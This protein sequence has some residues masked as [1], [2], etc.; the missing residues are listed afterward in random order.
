MT[1]GDNVEKRK[2]YPIELSYRYHDYDIYDKDTNPVRFNM[3]SGGIF[4]ADSGVVLGDTDVDGN[5]EIRDATWILR[6]AA[7]MDLP[8][9]ITKTTSDVDGNGE[10]NVIDATAIQYYLA[11]LKTNYP[12]GQPVT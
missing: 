2:L 11:Q 9:T 7:N 4:I 10:I 8:F 3:I 5:V 6:Y 12:I 1:G